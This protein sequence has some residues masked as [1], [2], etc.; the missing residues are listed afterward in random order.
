M[1]LTMREFIEVIKPKQ[2]M[3]LVITFII[4]YMV[5]SKNIALTHFLTSLA[6]VSFAIAGTTAI[7]MVFDYDIDRAMNRTALRPLPSGRMDKKVCF[8]YGFTVMLLG[9]A[10]AYLINPLFSLLLFLGFAIDIVIYTILLKRKTPLS[11]LFGGVAGAIPSLAGWVAASGNISIEGILLALIVFLWIPAHI[12]Y[13]AMYYYEDFMKAGVPAMPIVAGMQKTSWMIVLS[14]S[15]M[16]VVTASTAYFLSF[17]SY[18]TMLI[19][20]IAVY[21]IFKSLKFA[22]NPSKDN[23]MK[24]FKLANITLFAVYMAI[25]VSRVIL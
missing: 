2:T 7:N 24:M 23:A 13:L 1:N 6:A 16:L 5:A 25:F 9:V 11:I 8:A 4:A 3:L 15:A 14:A 17:N 18:L 10:I 21:F 19:A 20:I 12:W 22:V